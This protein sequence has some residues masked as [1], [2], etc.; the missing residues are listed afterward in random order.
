MS[1]TIFITGASSGIG[2]ATAELFA[3]KGWHVVAT[4]RSPEKGQ[5]L[6]A[7]DCIDVLRL[8]VTDEASIR[9]S[10]AEAIEKFGRI[11]VLLNNAGYGT[12][13]VAEFADSQETRRLYDT[14]V[15][16]LIEV[17]KAVLP[18]MRANRSGVVINVS[19]V[20]GRITFPLLSLYHGAKWAVEGF[21]EALSFEL[22]P[23]GIQ[24]KILEPGAI[25]TRF[26][27]NIYSHLGDEQSDY[28]PI[29]QKVMAR[30]EAMSENMSTPESVAEVVYEAATDGSDQLRYAASPDAVQLLK[31]RAEVGDEAFVKGMRLQ[32]LG[33]AVESIPQ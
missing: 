21:S 31:Q 10:V 11:D 16:G 25:S 1:K 32:M 3:E 15:I 2:R 4:M 17:T 23:L 27:G 12:I 14:H 8:D 18:N 29:V 26:M 6:A 9:Q 22:A 30:I 24:V 5:D 33:E 20:G 7:H 13:G 28:A 19:S